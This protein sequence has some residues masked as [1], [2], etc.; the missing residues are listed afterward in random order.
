M[1]A[2][3][4]STQAWALRY[5]PDHWQTMVF[6]VLSLSQLGHVLAIRSEREFLFSQGVFSNLPLLSAVFMTFILQLVVIYLPAANAAFKTQPLT[7]YE[8][9][10]CIIASAILFHAV[11]FEKWIKSLVGVKRQKTNTLT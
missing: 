9:A 8:L 4:L 10:I 2:I 3:T 1:A 6:T 11:E 5:R 7:L